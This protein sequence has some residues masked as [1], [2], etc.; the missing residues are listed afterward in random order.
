MM[1]EQEEEQSEAAVERRGREGASE[2]EEA[3][4][5]E[6]S[7]ACMMQESAN[8]IALE[9][10]RAG[11]LFYLARYLVAGASSSAKNGRPGSDRA[12][13]SISILNYEAIKDIS[14]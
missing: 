11:A 2:Q 6:H 14:R 12:H 9:C 3:A 4:A 13:I 7:R 8:G 1:S 5:K 10:G